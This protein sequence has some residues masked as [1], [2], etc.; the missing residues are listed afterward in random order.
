MGLTMSGGIT[1][2]GG[3]T[4]TGVPVS[5]LNINVGSISNTQSYVTNIRNYYD[6][7][8]SQ[9]SRPDFYTSKYKK[10]RPDGGITDIFYHSGIKRFY[11]VLFFGTASYT[12]N[13]TTSD[14]SIGSILERDGWGDNSGIQLSST[15]KSETV[16]SST[17]FW[18]GQLGYAGSGAQ[19]IDMPG[20]SSAAQDL[21]NDPN[22]PVEGTRC[23]FLESRFRFSSASYISFNE[24]TYDA[25]TA[26]DIFN[27]N[28]GDVK[29][30][31]LSR[32]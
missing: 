3:M 30:F 4:F 29:T 6:T 5:T 26:S 19:V 13:G 21:L 7:L 12:W 27:E 17:T 1:M 2:S 22:A 28:Y 20:K 9:G 16:S 14:Y 25:Y 31:K 10:V 18:S 11:G 8:T 32:S 24:T 15:L 23:V